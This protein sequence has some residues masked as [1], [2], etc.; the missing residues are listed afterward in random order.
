MT[1]IHRGKS[2]DFVNYNP[3]GL[4]QIRVPR[5]DDP[6]T[7][8]RLA[9]A[10]DDTRGMDVPQYRDGYTTVRRHWDE[11]VCNAIDGAGLERVREWAKKL[12]REPAVSV[13][14]FYNAT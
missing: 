4:L 9:R 13:E 10:W 8:G 5:L 14:G 11:A 7:I 1:L 6:R 3:E 2:L 12:N